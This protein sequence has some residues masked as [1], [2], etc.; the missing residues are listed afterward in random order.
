FARGI[1]EVSSRR[2]VVARQ[3]VFRGFDGRERPTRWRYVDESLR[4]IL[5]RDI[6]VERLRDQAREFLSG[7]GIIRLE[8]IVL[9]PFDDP[10]L[11]QTVDGVFGPECAAYILESGIALRAGRSRQG[12]RENEQKQHRQARQLLHPHS[13]PL[14]DW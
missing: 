2:R 4:R 1:E 8:R 3:E 9:V 12:Q 14:I 11:D 10:D 7:Y 6:Q 13:L 5:S